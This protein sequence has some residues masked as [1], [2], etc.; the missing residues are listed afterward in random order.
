MNK[1]LKFF[2]F[3]YTFSIFLLL[4][5]PIE[6]FGDIGKFNVYQRVHKAR[7]KIF[8]YSKDC[9]LKNNFLLSKIGL[10]NSSFLG[11]SNKKINVFYLENY[12]KWW[13]FYN[14]SLLLKEE[15]IYVAYKYQIL[16]KDNKI[17][18]SSEKKFING[19]N[20]NKLCP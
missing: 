8:L 12:I 6:R 1:K 2:Y 20:H 9:Q 3:F 7:I 19:N 13:T 16:N 14:K 11:L 18:F 15:A 4:I 5:I 17:K 10:K